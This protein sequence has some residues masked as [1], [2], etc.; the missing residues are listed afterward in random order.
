MQGTGAFRHGAANGTSSADFGGAPDPINSYDQGARA[1]TYI[2]RGAAG[3]AITQGIGVATGLQSK[4]SWAGVAAAG[5]G[6]AVGY[7]FDNKFTSSAV[8]ALANAA[9]RSAI[10]GSSFGDNLVAAIPDV[11]GQ[12]IG[13]AIVRGK[14]GTNSIEYR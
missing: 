3:S 1:G 14:C 6:G 9:T 7:N 13:D 12:A 4:L 11:I 10:D 5:V 8:S 2:V